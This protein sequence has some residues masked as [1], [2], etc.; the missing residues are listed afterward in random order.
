[1]K[2]QIVIS[3]WGG[4]RRASPYAFSEQGVAMLSSVLRSPRAVRVNVEIMRAFVRLR[5]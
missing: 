4:L 5:R 3:S 2:S 1:M